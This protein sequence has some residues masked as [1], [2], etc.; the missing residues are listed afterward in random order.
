MDLYFERHDGQAVTCDDFE[1]R[2]RF[3]DIPVRPVPS[4]LRGFSAPV[5]LRFD[6]TDEDLELLM[7]RDSDGFARWD[8]A[9]TLMERLL[10]GL[11]EEPE[12]TIP[13]RFFDAFRS[14]LLDQ[15]TDPALRAEVLTLPGESYLAD[16]MAVVDV[17]GIHRAR[18]GLRKQIG[19]ALRPELLGVYADYG[20]T[21][22]YAFSPGGVGRRALKNLALSYPMAQGDETA[23][24]LCR[25]QLDAA[26]NMTDT[27]AALRLVVDAGGDE[28]DE[29]LAAFHARWSHEPLVVDKWFSLQATSVRKDA[30]YRVMGLMSHPDFSLRNPNR[31]RSLVGAFCTGNPVRFHAA[32]G[33]GY[34]F[35]ADRV[36]ELDPL[37][38]QIASRLLRALIRWRRFDPARQGL[39]RAE[40]ERILAAEPLS[41]DAFEVASRALEA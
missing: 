13:G 8:A 16:Q 29:A 41:K 27:M 23:R 34:R 28:A 25:E 14:A 12:R 15:G 30:L 5:R 21:G 3:L 17:D 20:E 22:P 32:D 6:Y 33:S 19:M 2:F 31:V 40:L 35:L 7:A 39:M 36:L 11:V 18:E 24:R 10:L 9:Q 26:H 1:E 4:L 37:N 38:P